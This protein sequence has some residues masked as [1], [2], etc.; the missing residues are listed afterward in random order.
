MSYREQMKR[1]G[2]S[3]TSLKPLGTCHCILKRET[4]RIS[5]NIVLQLKATAIKSMTY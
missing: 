2:P 5:T 4:Y 3:N 1:A